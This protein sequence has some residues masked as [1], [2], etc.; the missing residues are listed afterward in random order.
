MLVLTY[1]RLNIAV[2]CGQAQSCPQPR[3]RRRHFLQCAPT[4]IFHFY[5]ASS[6]HLS[7][8]SFLSTATV[9]HSRTVSCSA[10]KDLYNVQPKAALSLPSGVG[11]SGGKLGAKG[12]VTDGQR[13]DSWGRLT[14]SL[15]STVPHMA[16]IGACLTLLS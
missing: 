10:E 6:Y 11:V 1:P 3:S 15:F 14:Q 13:W 4:T 16:T 2:I 9:F 8:L 12:S 7:C 5:H